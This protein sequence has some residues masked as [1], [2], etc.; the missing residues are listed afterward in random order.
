M[1]AQ[2]AAI[3]APMA[4]IIAAFFALRAIRLCSILS[5]NASRA[6]LALSEAEV[7]AKEAEAT[8][9]RCDEK[10][11]P[12][13]SIGQAISLSDMEL[14]PDFGD[15]EHLLNMRYW[16]QAAIEAKGAKQ[17]GAG[18]GMGNADIDFILEEHKFNIIIKPLLK[19]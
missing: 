10:P 15:P 7:A 1:I 14:H 11:S 6:L 2:I 17:T 16:L 19:S 9:S 4:A 8:A 5:A 3:I 13:S 12:I 18:F